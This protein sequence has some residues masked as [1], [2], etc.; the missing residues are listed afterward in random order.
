MQYREATQSDIP[1]L[2]Q[3]GASEW[4]TQEYR[5]MRISGYMN[6]ELICT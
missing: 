5:I 2:A 3:I 6:G 1:A 4:G